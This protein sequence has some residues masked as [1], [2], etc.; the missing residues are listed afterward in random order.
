M[1]KIVN[2]TKRYDDCVALNNVSL[3]IDSG[4]NI[5]IGQSGSGKSS[6]LNII[7]STFPA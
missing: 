6:L 1:L 5:I 7:Y 4:F 2:V 3:E